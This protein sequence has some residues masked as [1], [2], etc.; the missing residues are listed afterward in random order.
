ML[1]ATVD[2]TK[3]QGYIDPEPRKIFL[4]DFSKFVESRIAKDE[5]LMIGI[6]ANNNDQDTSD[7]RKCYT[8][9][10]LVDVFKRLQPGITPPNT[11]QQG[12]KWLDYIFITPALIPTL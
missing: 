5:E 9:N 7:F 12:K 4:Q 3:K 10:D 11:Y 2:A 1:G 8:K 6:D